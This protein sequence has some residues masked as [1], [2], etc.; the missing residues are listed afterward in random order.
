MFVVVTHKI[1]LF[2]ASRWLS[3]LVFVCFIVVLLFLHCF[4]PFSIVFAI[5]HNQMIGSHTGGLL[6]SLQPPAGVVPPPPPFPPCPPS[7]GDEFTFTQG[8]LLFLLCF[9]CPIKF[10]HSHNKCLPNWPNL[11][12]AHPVPWSILTKWLVWKA[13]PMINPYKNW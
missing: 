13:S 12:M 5:E 10:Q 8:W 11:F 4:S 2:L 3:R 6:G 9:N 1:P 7:T